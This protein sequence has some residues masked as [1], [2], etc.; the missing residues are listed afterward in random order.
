MTSLAQNI[1]AFFNTIG[2]KQKWPILSGMSASP[3]KADIRSDM[4]HVC[5]VPILLQKSFWGE[6]QKISRAADAF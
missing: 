3:P 4:A 2:Q 1:G 5:F 6:E